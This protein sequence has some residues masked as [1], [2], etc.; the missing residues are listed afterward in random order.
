MNLLPGYEHLVRFPYGRHGGLMKLVSRTVDRD[1]A[2]TLDAVIYLIDPVD[3]P[4][5]FPEAV[6]LKRQC[7]IHGKPFLPPWQ[8][9]RNG[10]SWKPSPT[11]HA[12]QFP[13]RPLHLKEEGIAL[14]AHDA[15]KRACWSWP[16]SISRYSTSLP[17]AVPPAPPAACSTSWR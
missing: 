7:V 16:K 2:R 14:I 15:M 8:G 1:P 11:G 3:P 17:S 9:P 6:A 13:G 10:S 12:R 4:S 5:T